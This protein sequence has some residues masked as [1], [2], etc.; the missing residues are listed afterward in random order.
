MR[1]QQALVDFLLREWLL[2]TSGVGL[3]ITSLYTGDLPVYSTGEFEVLFILFVLF[4]TVQ[5]LHKSGLLQAI[6][7][8]IERGR[9]IPLKL[10]LATFFLSM[11]VTN[12]IAL[13]V[14]VP[15]TLSLNI[16]QKDIIVI[17][18]AIAANAG[19]ALT[20][21]GNPQNLYIYWTY[22]VSAPLFIETMAPLSLAF[23]VLLIISSLFIRVESNFQV[24]QPIKV[25]KKSALIY[26]FFL[27]LVLG[28][29]FRVIPI[30]VGVVVVLF[31]LAFDRE[32]LRIDYALLLTFFFFFGMADNLQGI[33][34][35]RIGQS[36][37]IFV[38]SVLASQVMSNVPAVL[39]FSNFTPNWQALL[40]GSNVGGF[41]SLFGSLANLIAYK[42]YVA[43]QS[44]G[45]GRRFTVKFLVIGYLALFFSM[46][47]Y[48]VLH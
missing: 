5:G 48:F 33:L 35:A 40:W 19:S 16:N 25:N 27:M 44:T 31:A 21:M 22:H 12:D 32:A 30:F 29:V 37:H 47:L 6:A 43:H 46:A 1:S 2:V 9:S 41:G 24:H 42:L 39:L 28:A 38:F 8:V 17:L 11:V 14:L 4:I 18:E 26:A 7:R 36:G 10:V 13:I 20:P 23:V 34:R 45:E 15:L 3:V